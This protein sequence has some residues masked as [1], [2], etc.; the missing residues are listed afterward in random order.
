MLDLE[1]KKTAVSLGGLFEFETPACECFPECALR[2]NLTYEYPLKIKTNTKAKILPHRYCFTTNEGLVDV[3]VK[4]SKKQ[5]DENIRVFAS[6]R[7]SNIITSIPATS[8]LKNKIKH[9]ANQ[10]AFRL[11]PTS[12]IIKAEFEGNQ[13]KLL[14]TDF[15]EKKQTEALAEYIREFGYL[16]NPPKNPRQINV[17]NLS[18]FYDRLYALIILITEL[19]KGQ[20]EM[21]CNT[22]FYCTTFLANAKQVSLI[23][24]SKDKDEEKFS[25][26]HEFSKAWENAENISV[27]YITDG[28][29]MIDEEFFAIKEGRLIELDV[30]NPYLHPDSKYAKHINFSPS[31]PE[32]ATQRDNG[33]CTYVYD[34][35]FKKKTRL[36]FYTTDDYFNDNVYWP[37]EEDITFRNKICNLYVTYEGDSD[38]RELIEFL[39][40][41]YAKYPSMTEEENGAFSFKHGLD[42]NRTYAFDKDDMKLLMSIAKKV[43]KK[44]MDYYLSNIHPVY[45]ADTMTTSWKIPDLL[46]AMYFSLFYYNPKHTIYKVCERTDCG[47]LIVVT[48]TDTKK[49]YCS[50]KC[51]GIV[52]QRRFRKKAQEEK[53]RS[54]FDV[55]V[56]TKQNITQ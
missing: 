22:L 1:Y 46:T 12:L 28:Y 51:N 54:N 14:D 56:L 9:F 38:T 43:I 16:F 50:S 2:V 11:N 10:N 42:L 55:E 39:M 33:N 30:E 18:A 21:D 6:S 49:K 15:S 3:N 37:L 52:T 19:N 5:T 17:E 29:D 23:S 26:C 41:I 4:K 44:E 25:A 45:D 53:Q 24:Y 47:N 7:E 8:T 34:N 20:L 48:S 36:S 32:G 27:E 13:K 35:I 40:H 31:L